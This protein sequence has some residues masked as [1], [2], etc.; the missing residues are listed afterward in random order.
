MKSSLRSQVRSWL[1]GRNGLVSNTLYG[2]F[3]WTAVGK[4][5]TRLKEA[6][7][8]GEPASPVVPPAPVNRTLYAISRLEQRLFGAAPVPFGSSL[9]AVGGRGRVAG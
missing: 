3:H 5:A 7:V 2:F 8:P 9:L 6:L 4:V 1:V